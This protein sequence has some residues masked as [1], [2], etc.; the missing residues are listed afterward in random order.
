MA[1]RLSKLDLREMRKA[2]D[3]PYGYAAPRFN[4]KTGE[5]WLAQWRTWNRLQDAELAI[6][7]GGGEAEDL[8]LT[9]EGERRLRNYEARRR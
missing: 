4:P 3:H 1:I 6:I 7:E 5:Q 8:A 2:R 9:D